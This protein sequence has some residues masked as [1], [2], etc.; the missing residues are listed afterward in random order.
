MQIKVNAEGPRYDALMQLLRTADTIWN[1]SR[2]LFDRWEISPSQF[3]ILNLLYNEPAGLSQVELSRALIMHRSNVTGLVDRL[4]ARDLVKRSDIPGDRRAYRVSLTAAGKKLVGQIL[5]EYFTAAEVIWGEV[6]T[7][8]AAETAK[9]LAVLEANARKAADN[10]K[11]KKEA[12]PAG[13]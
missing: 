12:L 10:I 5:P 2:M 8:K 6:P 7:A 9:V 11:D 4:E 13:E 1:S 3:N